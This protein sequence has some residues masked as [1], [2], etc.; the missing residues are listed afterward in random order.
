MNEELVVKY[1][2]ILYPEFD[3]MEPREKYIAVND[4]IL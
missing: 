1:F 4:Q 2:E 3:S